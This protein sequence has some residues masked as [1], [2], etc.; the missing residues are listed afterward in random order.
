MGWVVN[1]PYVHGWRSKWVR[2]SLGVGSSSRPCSVSLSEW[3]GEGLSD[4]TFSDANFMLGCPS[5]ALRRV[6]P[7]LC[8]FSVRLHTE[9]WWN[10]KSRFNHYN[11]G[12]DNTE[13]LFQI[14]TL[15]WS[16]V[17]PQN[18]LRGKDQQI[19]FGSN[20]L[21]P[22]KPFERWDFFWCH[23]MN[24]NNSDVVVFFEMNCEAEIILGTL[25][26]GLTI[27]NICWVSVRLRGLCKEYVRVER[28]SL[29]SCYRRA[30]FLG[31]C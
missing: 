18:Q 15:L 29:H 19:F 21:I 14:L 22:P 4:V 20:T 7:Q 12:F 28:Y 3:W 5:A 1:L 27:K 30:G 24:S 9:V 23:Q 2:T 25:V 10:H 8:I 31:G 17:D 11:Q 26:W 16:V 13:K 6:G